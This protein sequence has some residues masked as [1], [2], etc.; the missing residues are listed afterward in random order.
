MAEG[1]IPVTTKKV[2]KGNYKNHNLN[3]LPLNGLNQ[4]E[5]ADSQ[6]HQGTKELVKDSRLETSE[7]SSHSSISK[8]SKDYKRKKNNTLDK[9]L[10]ELWLENYSLMY[11]TDH[12][13]MAD[14]E[15]LVHRLISDLL[16]M[17]SE[18]E[19]AYSNSLHQK[20]AILRHEE[21]IT[22]VMV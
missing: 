17:G 13:S 9:T 6:Q 15:Q 19:T 1:L 14:N 20:T 5:F 12:L 18:D 8:L 3:P 2:A 4:P 21:L 22:A 10:L 7:D 11:L 16:V